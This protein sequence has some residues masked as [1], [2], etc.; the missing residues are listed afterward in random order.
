MDLIAS[1]VAG[2]RIGALA[3]GA[4]EIMLRLLEG[5]MPP[6]RR[7]AAELVIRDSTGAAPKE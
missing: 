2:L 3:M 4:M 5:E 7:L 1:D 6:V